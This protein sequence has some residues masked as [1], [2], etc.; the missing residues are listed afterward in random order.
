MSHLDEGTLHALLDGELDLAEVSEVQKH[1]GSCVACGSRLQE[2]KQ[3]LAEADSLV[4]VM[5]VPARAARS[6]PE[7]P[8][9]SP[10]PPPPPA[11]EPDAWDEPPVLL[12]PD[13]IDANARRR[14]WA[15]GLGLAAALAVVV[16]GGKLVGNV[17]QPR[18]GGT[19]PDACSRRASS[20]KGS[21]TPSC[22]GNGL[23]GGA[24]GHGCRCRR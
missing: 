10:A 13:P 12:V 21:Y 6:R 20:C 9:R 1:L 23:G 4:G 3:V 17:F 2:V 14:R 18:P 22:R 8:P 24:C 5:E 19:S 15:R 7:P 16:A 11:R